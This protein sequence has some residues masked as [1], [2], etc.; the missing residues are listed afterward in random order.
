MFVTFFN[1]FNVFCLYLNVFYIYAYKCEV[2]TDQTTDAYGVLNN[3]SHR[4]S[5]KWVPTSIPGAK[6]LMNQITKSLST[7]NNSRNVTTKI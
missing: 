4:F 5:T 2:I 6:T 1:V 7:C 3:R